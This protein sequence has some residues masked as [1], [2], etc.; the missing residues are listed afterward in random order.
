MIDRLVTDLPEPDSPTTASVSPASSVNE[1]SSTALTRPASVSK[2]VRRWR[3]SSSGA[4]ERAGGGRGHSVLRSL[5]SSRSRRPSPTI[6]SDSAERMIANPGNTHQPDRLVRELLAAGDHRAPGRQRGRNADAE[7][8]QAR[9]GEHGVGEDEGR[10]HQDRRRDVLQDVDE[11]DAPRR[12]AQRA[13]GLDEQQLAHD[14]R[15]GAHH[16]G[17]ARR[18]DD[19]QR[20]DHVGHRCAQHRDE[21]DREQDVGERHHRVDHPHDRAVEPAEVPGGEPEQRRRRSPR[22]PPPARRS[23]ASSARRRSR[24]RTRRGRVRRC[25][26]SAWRAGSAAGRGSSARSG[27]TA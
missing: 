7:K 17:H 25:R 11:Q 9:L 2:W 22:S 5:G 21:R 8:R 10:L 26:T 18:V 14:Q 6:C 4:A 15:G 3:T 19:R 24:A 13:R 27:R 23:S 1:T 16:A 20:E 12:N